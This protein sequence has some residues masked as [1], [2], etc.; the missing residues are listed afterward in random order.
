MSRAEIVKLLLAGHSDRSIAIRLRVHRSR[1]RD[2]RAELG[3]PKRK[4]G[5]T[6]ASPEDAFWQRA[7]P[8]GDGHL[9]WPHATSTIRTG[10]EGPRISVARVAFRLGNKREPVGKV[11]TGCDQPGCIHP[12]HVEDRLMRQQYAAIFGTAA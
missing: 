8:T 10:H 12:Q 1:A 4:P 9:L 3:L 5:R 11:T 7:V 6:P 2:L